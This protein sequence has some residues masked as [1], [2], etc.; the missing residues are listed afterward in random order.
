MRRRGSVFWITESSRES[1]RRD[2]CL[3]CT[4]RSYDKSRRRL[5]RRKRDL[6]IFRSAHRPLPRQVGGLPSTLCL[7]QPPD[8][9]MRMQSRGNSNGHLCARRRR[10]ETFGA[11]WPAFLMCITRRARHEVS[12]PCRHALA[13]RHRHWGQLHRSM[14]RCVQ[15]SRELQY[16]E[17]QAPTRRSNTGSRAYR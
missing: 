13:G 16:I 2:F 5:L 6:P 4:I 14:G 3:H 1:R 11:P 9:A 15:A 10:F 12:V 8:D 7:A 17:P